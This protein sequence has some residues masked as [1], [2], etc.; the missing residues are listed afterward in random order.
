MAFLGQTFDA[1]NVAPSADISPV[2]SGEYVAIIVDSDMKPTKSGNGQYLELVHELVD[3]PFRGRKVWGR[4]NLSNP[5]A[6]TVQIAQEQLSSICHATGVM[7]VQDSQQLHNRPLVI[8]VEFV[9]ADG[10][11]RQ[12][13][14]NEIKAWKRYEGA[15]ATPPAASAQPTAAA[16]TAANN[17][18][19]PWQRPRAA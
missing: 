18:L 10:Q 8:R 1:N 12:R 5:N 9:P 4:L 6:K 11:Q 13:D 14:G 16:P 19:P 2:P 15:G 7:Q 17:T 3:G